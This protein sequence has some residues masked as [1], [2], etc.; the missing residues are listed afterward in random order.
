M[1]RSDSVDFNVV[2]EGLAAVRADRPL[3]QCLTNTVTCNFVANALLAVGATPAMVDIPEESGLFAR[4]VA[5]AVLVNLGTPAAEQRAAMLEAVRDDPARP[6]WVLDPVAVGALPV[7]TALAEELVG[8]HPTVVRGN[9]SEVA[10]LAGGGAGGRGVDSV[11]AADAALGAAQELAR[12]SGGVVAVSGAVDVITDG[13]TVV[14]VANGHP[15][16]A[17]ITGGGCALGAVVAA[18]VAASGPPLAA[19]AAA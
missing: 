2:I 7:R 12:R 19:T 3:V 13:A 4:Q 8:R 11:L 18:F 1:T 10:A 14:R 6:P 17:G 9:A 15:W 16:M 5:S